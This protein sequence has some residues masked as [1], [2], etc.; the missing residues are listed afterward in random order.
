MALSSNEL[1]KLV[2][3]VGLTKEDEI[4]C[5][6]CLSKVAEFAEH[7]LADRS[8]PDGLRAVEHHLSTCDECREE[9]QALQQVLKGM[10]N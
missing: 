3:L 1:N 5:E 6:R 8:I 4:D 2:R 10:D 9:F 7:T